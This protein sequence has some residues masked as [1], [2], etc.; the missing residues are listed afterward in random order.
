MR[1]QRLYELY[2][3]EPD[4]EIDILAD[5]PHVVL[6]AGSAAEVRNIRSCLSKLAKRLD[7]KVMTKYDEDLMR[8]KIWRYK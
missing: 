5:K 6:H 3:V 4:P 7:W 1:H 2:D 8:L